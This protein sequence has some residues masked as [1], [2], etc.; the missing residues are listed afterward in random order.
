MIALLV[1]NIK[2][3][4]NDPLTLLKSNVLDVVYSDLCGPIKVK[5]LDGALYFL[6]F[7][8]DHSRK[9]WAYTLKRSSVGYVPTIP[10]KS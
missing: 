10:S 6:T 2:F 7:V 1:S 3:H 9:V 4:S 8:E 5:T